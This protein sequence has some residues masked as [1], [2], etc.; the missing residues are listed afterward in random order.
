MLMVALIY[1]ALKNARRLTRAT[2][3]GEPATFES[4]PHGREVASNPRRGHQ[5]ITAALNATD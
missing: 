4:A 2:V 5:P 3:R 1:R